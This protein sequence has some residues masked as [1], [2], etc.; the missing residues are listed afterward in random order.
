M[1]VIHFVVTVQQYNRF[2]DPLLCISDPFSNVSSQFGGLGEPL[3][4]LLEVDNRPDGVEVLYINTAQIR[5][6]TSTSIQV[7]VH[8]STLTLR[9]WR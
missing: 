7:N 1:R 4:G 3:L 2:H 9:Y 8:T 6:R 5:I